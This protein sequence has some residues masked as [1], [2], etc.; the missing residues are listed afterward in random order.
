MYL[1]DKSTWS[2][3]GCFASTL[4]VVT[5]RNV[6]L[7]PYHDYTST[8]SKYPWIPK[9]E[10]ADPGLGA[11]FYKQHV[12]DRESSS[13]SDSQPRFRNQ[14]KNGVSCRNGR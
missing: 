13:K 5:I 8:V 2:V 14:N 6:R 9:T 11:V 1:I 10:Y 3:V 12:S 4:I 7:F